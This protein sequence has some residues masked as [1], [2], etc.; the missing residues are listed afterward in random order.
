MNQEKPKDEQKP[1]NG[2]PVI[3]Y[4]LVMFIAA[5]LLMALSM[6]MHQRTT[7]EGLGELQ[8]SFSAMLSLQSH[9]EMVIELQNAL[10]EADDQREA[11]E[12]TIQTMTEAQETQDLQMKALTQLYI[13]QQQYLAGEYDHCRGTI[14]T[15]ETL[16]LEKLLPSQ[17]EYSVPSPAETFQ[18]IKAELDALEATEAEEGSGDV[19]R[20]TQG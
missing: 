19:S 3:H 6:M 16:E 18:T 7:S 14:Q 5:F 12:E 13:L 10:N 9:Q 8:H 11:L 2:K 17:K 1:H 20:E 4:I 15:M